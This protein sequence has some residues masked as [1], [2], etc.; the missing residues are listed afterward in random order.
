[1][2]AM[3]RDL[4]SADE[5][6]SRIAAL[7][8]HLRESATDAALVWGRGGGSA[9]RYADVRYLTGYYPVFPTIRDLDGVWSDRGLCAVLV[10]ATDIVLFSDEAGAENAASGITE[11]VFRHGVGP[12]TLVGDI[13]G[14]LAA[15]P[16]LRSLVLVATDAM[17]GKH[18]LRLADEPAYAALTVSEDNAAV[19]TLRVRKS[20]AEIALL[21]AAA[22][23]AEEALEAGFARI[24]PGARE[25]DVVAAMAEVVTR[26]EAALANAF[27]Y[28]FQAAGDCEDNRLPIHSAREF[29]EGD[30]FTVD[31]SGSYA[32][33]FFDLAR[34]VVVG[35]RPTADQD[36][37]YRL[38][39]DTVD[40]VVAAFKPGVVLGDAAQAGSAL[41]RAA[42]VDPEKAEFAARGHGLGLGFE[43][44]WIR[45]DSALVLEVGMVLSVE[46]F[47]FVGDTGATYERN[48]VIT[49]DGVEDLVAVRDFWRAF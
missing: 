13:A 9:D 12:R 33:Y 21:R 31:L 23:I 16:V 39:R 47:C 43:A 48:L 28:T 8:S 32:G 24:L 17:S 20:A 26:R 40:I 37:A 45:D 3:P 1:M 30:L 25:A 34:S 41:L 49:P 10:T 42:G 36:A 46:Q 15:R 44:P 22:A 38:A 14:A 2:D 18:A 4:I 11:S 19:E 35:G 27:V 7:R 6:A 5:Y 29:A